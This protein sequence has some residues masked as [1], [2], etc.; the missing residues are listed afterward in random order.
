MITLRHILGLGLFILTAALIYGAW[1]W[2][3]DFARWEPIRPIR[4]ILMEWR[5]PIVAVGSF[6]FLTLAEWAYSKTQHPDHED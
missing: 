5:L 6:L 4:A 3:P 1:T 2:F